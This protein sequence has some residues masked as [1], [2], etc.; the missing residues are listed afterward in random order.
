MMIITRYPLT[1]KNDPRLCLLFVKEGFVLNGRGRIVNRKRK[2]AGSKDELSS[3]FVVMCTVEVKSRASQRRPHM[4][5]EL[6]N[7]PD[8]SVERSILLI[9]SQKVILDRTL[10]KLY[11]VST[12][13]LNQ[14]VK[15]N[16][17]RF[18]PDFMFQL[19]IEEA[20]ALEPTDES[21]RSQTV[22]LKK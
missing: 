16:P 1:W 6:I 7:V 14:A 13:V 19:S 20:K 5:H 4:T 21:L 18:P 11:G 12:K 22:T 17:E 15:R 3:G 8:E 2:P 10:A 9:R